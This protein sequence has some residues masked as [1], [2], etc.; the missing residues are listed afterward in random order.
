MHLTAVQIILFVADQQRS[1]DFYSG[2]LELDP[3]TDVPGMTEFALPGI[4]LGLMQESGIIKIL[5]DAVPNPAEASGVPRCELYLGCTDVDAAFHNALKM[6][7]VPVSP[8]QPRN[9]GDTAGYVACPDGHIIAFASK[10]N[11]DG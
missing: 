10:T 5:K 9:W 2:L 1:R 7:A 3:V 8:P 11:Q 4:R 6:G